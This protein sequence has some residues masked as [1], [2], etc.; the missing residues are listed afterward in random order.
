MSSSAMLEI[1]MTLIARSDGPMICL[2]Q[3]MCDEMYILFRQ[4]KPSR[5][6]RFAGSSIG[7]G[8]DDPADR[9]S[10][11]RRRHRQGQ[12]A[13]QRDLGP[14]RVPSVPHRADRNQTHQVSADK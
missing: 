7:R 11:C 1:R 12:A 8:Q 9:H 2:K 6:P 14:L 13:W 3:H 4:R 5:I 10:V